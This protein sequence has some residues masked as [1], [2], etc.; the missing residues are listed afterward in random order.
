LNQN[1]HKLQRTGMSIYL[2]FINQN[3][4]NALIKLNPKE[5]I[6]NSKN[7]HKYKQ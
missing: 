4:I 5:K 2:N 6:I 7:K 3:K 1:Q